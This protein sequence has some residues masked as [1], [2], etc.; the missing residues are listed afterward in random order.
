MI[1]LRR[2][3]DG[4]IAEDSDLRGLHP[5]IAERM[6]LWRMSNF[7]L[8]RIPA[9]QEVHL[10]RA[11]ARESER[12]ERLVAMAEVR[13]LTAVRDE[14]DGS[15]RCPSSS[16]SRAR[17]SSLSGRSSRVGARASVCTGTA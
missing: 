3:A 5:M 1:T 7:T 14:R 12:D 15:W 10:F 6:D 16:G 8:E 9:D 13:D 17:R 4:D 11:V 2:G